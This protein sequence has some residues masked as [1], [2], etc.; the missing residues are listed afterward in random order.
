MRGRGALLLAW[1]AWPVL[2]TT[3][4]AA[5]YVSAM[6]PCQVSTTVAAFALCLRCASV[7]CTRFPG[8][9]VSFGAMASTAHPCQLDGLCGNTTEAV[10][11]LVCDDGGYAGT[12]A[13]AAPVPGFAVGSGVFPYWAVGLVAGV[14]ALMC[15]GLCLYARTQ[16]A[17]FNRHVD[18][19]RRTE[20]RARRAE[21]RRKRAHEQPR[22]PSRWQSSL[23]RL[24]MPPPPPPGPPPNYL[25]ATVANNPSFEMA[26]PPALGPG[27]GAPPGPPPS[28]G[29]QGLVGPPAPPAQRAS[30]GLV[31]PPG[32]GPPPLSRNATGSGRLPPPPLPPASR[33]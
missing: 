12:C 5:A 4:P 21:R 19:D 22:R 2:A 8:C 20:L 27:P 6:G 14:G 7:T 24:R 32:L 10:M 17:R 23:Q 29:S 13:P 9:G 15:V 26:M 31:G 11:D 28:R 16:I 3:C 18:K 33:T 30:Q 25:S 1:A